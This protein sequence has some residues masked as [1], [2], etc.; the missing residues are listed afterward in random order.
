MFRS[1]LSQ[2]ALR[3]FVPHF[4][5]RTSLLPYFVRS[6]PDVFLVDILLR[7]VLTTA[8][9]PGAPRRIACS[10]IYRYRRPRPGCDLA[11]C[12]MLLFVLYC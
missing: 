5:C 10:M 4:D 6:T 7:G 1:A 12:D 11:R 2:G 3:T 9:V 8:Y